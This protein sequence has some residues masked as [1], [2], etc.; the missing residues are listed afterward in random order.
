MTGKPYGA[1]LDYKDY[2]AFERNLKGHCLPECLVS[3][4][5]PS[6]EPR[7]CDVHRNT[8]D[9]YTGFRLFGQHF[10]WPNQ[11]I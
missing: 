4:L 5:L 6:K 9:D 8:F 7:L 11:P 10:C 1:T 3:H 2:A